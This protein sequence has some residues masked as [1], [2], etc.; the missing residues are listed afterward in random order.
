[1]TNKSVDYYSLLQGLVVWRESGVSLF[2]VVCCCP[3]I[4]ADLRGAGPA[5]LDPASLTQS[6]SYI[7]RS[8]PPATVLYLQ[9]HECR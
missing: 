3:I 8:M 9:V 5:S 4:C 6:R 7:Y 1:M 2:V